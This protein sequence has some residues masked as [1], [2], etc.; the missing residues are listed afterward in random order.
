MIMS[1]SFNISGDEKD[2]FSIKGVFIRHVL[3]KFMANHEQMKGRLQ[4]DLKVLSSLR[5][6][7]VYKDD[8]GELKLEKWGQCF[9]EILR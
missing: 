6:E 7:A 2:P 8:F 1:T 3:S 4:N 5:E 9:K